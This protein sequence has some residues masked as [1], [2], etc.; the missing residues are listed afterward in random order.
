MLVKTRDIITVPA[1]IMIRILASLHQYR[2]LIHSG[3]EVTVRPRPQVQEEEEEDDDEDDDDDD[4]DEDDENDEVENELMD[5]DEHVAVVEGVIFD[6]SDDEEEEEPEEQ[7]QMLVDEE[8]QLQEHD[9][10]PDLNNANTDCN[11]MSN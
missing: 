4:D 9:S 7:H 5:T 11:Q 10:D 1:Q 6:L 8:V 2:R 3:G